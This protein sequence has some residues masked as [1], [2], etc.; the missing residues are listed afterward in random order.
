M[1]VSLQKTILGQ[2]R[3]LFP[4]AK[5]RC[6]LIEGSKMHKIQPVAGILMLVLLVC[7]GCG[8]SDL[9]D[10]GYVEGT[11]T[12]D[13][14][15]LP[16]AIVT[17]QPER[18][19]PSYGRT[20]ENGWYELAYTDE[21]KGATLGTHQVTISTKSDGDPDADPPVPS[22]PE[23]VPARYNMKSE[24]TAEVKAGDNECNFP[25]ESKGE[26]VE[27]VEEDEEG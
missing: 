2:Q 3:G 22:S 12:L 4:E 18:A 1:I 8:G 21:A 23:K 10:L 25:L 24:L 14:N 7:A 9:P 13:G 6:V 16:N 19:R 15:P 26:I 17:F 27:E 5:P 11:V 20:D